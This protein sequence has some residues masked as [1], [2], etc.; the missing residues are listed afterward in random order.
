LNGNLAIITFQIV[1]QNINSTQ[2]ANVVYKALSNPNTNLV[3]Q[4][5][6][7]TSSKLAPLTSG[8]TYAADPT[9]LSSGFFSIDKKIMSF[10]SIF[11]IISSLVIVVH[12]VI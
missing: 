4:G 8:I 5:A 10:Y 3:I 2:E 6:Y 11:F 7:V 9:D 12:V 1:V